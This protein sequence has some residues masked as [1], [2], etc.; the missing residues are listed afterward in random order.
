M[1]KLNKHGASSK[2]LRQLDTSGNTVS[3]TVVR[4]DEQ[5]QLG[6][7]AQC[8]MVDTIGV[9]MDHIDPVLPN[10]YARINKSES[11]D[12]E[13][14]P[15]SAWGKTSMSNHAG[16]RSLS[17]RK[18]LKKQ[19]GCAATPTVTVEGSFPAYAQGHNVVSTG[20]VP[21][22]CYV[23]FR[24]VNG[25]YPLIAPVERKLAIA[26]GQDI[27]VSRI[28]VDLLLKVPSRMNMGDFINA[29][30]FAGFSTG[31]P[32]KV[33]P[34]EATYFD[35]SSQSHAVK[36]Y[37]KAAENAS[38]RKPCWP[39]SP[40]VDR[41][42]QVAADFV[43][44]EFVFRQKY[45]L[46]LA[47]LGGELPHPEWFTRERLAQ[48]VLKALDKLNLQGQLET[49]L[50]PHALQEILLPYRTT[51]ALW[52]NGEDM[53]MHMVKRTVAEHRKYLLEE[54][55]IDI[56]CPPPSVFGHIDLAEVLSPANFVPVPDDVRAD[57]T[58][59]YDEDINQTIERFERVI[60]NMRKVA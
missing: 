43:R 10:N 19:R 8:I 26:R 12:E 33:F 58:L 42:K 18:G 5:Q 46:G 30:A 47:E 27:R 37:D 60:A 1:Q 4:M 56:G 6:H 41:L 59:F 3:T 54:H 55:S 13:H 50:P 32:I 51:V 22:L 45:F 15:D 25:K 2:G 11:G 14:D 20:D 24:A 28:D 44:V 39:D 29:I 16:K 17:I 36:F 53:E 21:L 48:M 49:R 34:R 40:N 7:V 57:L 31:L 35:P 23:M 38:K 9:I 52:Q